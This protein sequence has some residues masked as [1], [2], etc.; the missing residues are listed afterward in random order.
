MNVCFHLVAKYENS[1]L[2]Q[3]EADHFKLLV[4]SDSFCPSVLLSFCRANTDYKLYG[5][6]ER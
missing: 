2:G 4:D 6:T 1:T 5:L 3:L